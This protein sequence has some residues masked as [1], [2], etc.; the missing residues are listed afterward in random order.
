LYNFVFRNASVAGAP[1]GDIAVNVQR[2]RKGF[3]PFCLIANIGDLRALHALEEYDATGF[4][5]VQRFREMRVG[6]LAELLFY[7]KDR[8]VDWAATDLEKQFPPDAIFSAGKWAVGE[9]VIPRK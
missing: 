1:S 2:Q 7:K 9:K 5:V 8:T 6:S 4:N 3:N